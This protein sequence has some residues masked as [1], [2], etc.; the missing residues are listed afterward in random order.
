MIPLALLT[1]LLAAPIE[2]APEVS[3]N[4]VI[5]VGRPDESVSPSPAVGIVPGSVLYAGPGAFA[6]A[7]RDSVARAEKYV[8]LADRLKETYRLAAVSPES[9]ES[10]RLRL[11]QTQLVPTVEAGPSVEITPL[12]IDPRGTTYRVRLKQGEALLA[13]PTLVVR[14]NGL[15]ILGTRDGSAAPYLFVVLEDAAKL[16]AGVR[17]PKKIFNVAPTF[18]AEAKEARVQG[19]VLIHCRVDA[20]GRM[21]HAEVLKGIQGEAGAMLNE[22]ALEAVRQW[23]YEPAVDERGTPVEAEMTIT[24]NFRLAPPEARPSK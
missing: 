13:E 8:T 10:L 5:L 9:T 14:P 11:D 3:L 15:A 23:R 6:F 12:A 22:A 1:A 2:A 16:A 7:G 21:A 20:E 18:P 4:V 17:M 19:I 24:I